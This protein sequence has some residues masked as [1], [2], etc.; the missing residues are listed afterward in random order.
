MK[1]TLLS[2]TIA[3]ILFSGTASAEVGPE[4]LPS[5]VVSAD[6]RPAAAQDIP[7]SLTTFDDTIIES[8]G[9]QHIEDVL[10]LAPNVNI[11]SG[12]SRGQYFQIRGIGE[13]SQFSAP[14]NPSVG[15]IIDG[16]DFS[17]TGGAATLFD[18]EQVEVL[19]GPQGTRYG[20][21]ALAG[22]VNL[23]SKQATNEFDMNFE[24]T[25]ADYDTREIGIAVGGPI[26]K[27]A[28]LG[29]IAVHTHQSDGYMDNDF[30][31]RDN[32]QDRD[33][34]TARG[35]LKFL[36]SDDLTV[37][38]NLLHLNIDNGYD[39]FSFDNSR[40]TLSDQPGEDKQ[41]TNAL[42][43]K[44][45]WQINNAVSMQSALTYSKSDI[46]YSYD[47]DWG[48]AGIH[49][50]EYIATE[51]FMR[52]RE[53]VSFESRLISDEAGRIF[54]GSTDWVLGFYHLSQDEDLD[55]VSDFGNLQNEY[56]TENTAVFGQ[57]DTYLTSKLTLIS[58]LRV[59]R[60]SADYEDSNGLDLDPS[61]TLFGG[62]L[63][64]NYQLNADHM[65]FTSLS[66]G[67]KSGGVNN[68]DAL[69]LSKREF[70][71][72]YMWNLEAGL[73]SSWLDGDLV[74]NLTA[75][76]AWRRD[77]QVKSSIALPGGEFLD[78]LDNAARGT[79]VGI[80]F[81]ADWLVN[82]K[83]RLFAA[84]GLL[85]ATFDEYDNPELQAEGFDIEGRRQ[86]H[87]PAYQFTLGGEIYL[88]Q[89][90]TLRANVEGKDEFYFSNSHN[91]KS[92]SYAIT[93]ASLE[94]QHQNWRVTLWGRN[95]FD[96]DYYTRGFFFGNDPRIGYADKAYKQLGDPRVVGLTV[97][98][99][100]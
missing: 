56:E 19:R 98:Y 2:I 97:S 67:Y 69:P 82:D 52:E 79:N 99:D 50:D 48:F 71:T 43:L 30:L 61:E 86:A 66:R 24:S 42:A 28:L 75:F 5:M 72:E 7:V 85:R 55:L 32:T 60:F 1:P 95:L 94:Y 34:I 64:L 12:A 46:T 9:A 87:A 84:V 83:L 58:G 23:Q 59:E 17:R 25:L 3:S 6:F 70:D 4:D 35:H 29:R 33:E 62:K 65:A 74:T 57:L 21:N 63:G 26:V 91:A 13:R 51:N 100:Y 45:D 22:V 54:G 36:V 39:A 11:S 93:N 27:D 31:G 15:L 49:P 37:D 10:N 44:S 41:R 81:D 40:S 96:K 8:R 80:E 73:K 78:S 47:A 88:N 53:N 20:T 92:G 68:N 76:Y 77:A 16:I 90:W 38:L 89:N 18:I 14:L